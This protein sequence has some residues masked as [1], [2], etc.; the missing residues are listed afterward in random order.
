MKRILILLTMIGSVLLLAQGVLAAAP[1]T[2]LDFGFNQELP[3]TQTNI[4]SE[5]RLQLANVVVEGEA[6]EYLSLYEYTVETF[7]SSGN[8]VYGSST[9][10]DG[11]YLEGETVLFIWTQNAPGMHSVRVRVKNKGA[12]DTEY[13]EATKT[14]EILPAPLPTVFDFGFDKTNPSMQVD[15]Y[16]EYMVKFADVV[17]TGEAGGENVYYYEF[18]YETRSPTGEKIAGSFDYWE[19][20]ELMQYRT[21]LLLHADPGTY[22]ITARLRNKLASDYVEVVKTFDVLVSD[23]PTAA[24]L[25]IDGPVYQDT[26]TTAQASVEGPGIYTYRF[27]HDSGSGYTLL[28]DWSSSPSVSIPASETA[29]VGTNQVKLEVQAQ[30][31]GSITVRTASYQVELGDNIPFKFDPPEKDDP[32]YAPE[33]GKGRVFIMLEAY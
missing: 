3:V 12:L 5:Y 6:G 32:A 16:P 25:S 13:I 11:R 2:S 28:S 15:T 30:D 7:D 24:S 14:F 22:T 33:L 9:W 27:W 8:L 1:P 17:F 26:A 23:S 20:I 18:S 19:R 10:R 21:A 31:S 4:S 29:E